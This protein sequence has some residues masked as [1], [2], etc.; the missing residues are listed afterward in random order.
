MQTKRVEHCT[1]ENRLRNDISHSCARACQHCHRT[2]ELRIR[3]GAIRSQQP[4][5]QFFPSHGQYEIILSTYC[6]CTSTPAAV[7]TTVLVSKI[8]G[9]PTAWLHGLEVQDSRTFPVFHVFF[10]YH[11]APLNPQIIDYAS[12][13]IEWYVIILSENCALHDHGTGPGLT[14][15]FAQ[16]AISRRSRRRG[17]QLQIEIVHDDRPIIN[18]ATLKFAGSDT[19]FSPE[20][21]MP[22]WPP[23]RGLGHLVYPC[24]ELAAGQKSCGGGVC[25]ESL[26]PI[27]LLMSGNLACMNFHSRRSLPLHHDSLLQTSRQA[28]YSAHIALPLHICF[29]NRR[30]LACPSYLPYH[31]RTA[32]SSAATR[33]TT[34]SKYRRKRRRRNRFPVAWDKVANI[35]EPTRG[36]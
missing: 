18:L 1:L 23:R 14:A 35:L 11:T 27:S 19:T 7:L 8:Y 24:G 12:R 16:K 26:T 33:G 22:S 34:S 10:S 13:A 17:E 5:I 2:G 6:C 31:L 3:D 36:L 29:V 25:P 21:R 28:F 32:T 9:D 4:S 20:R 15:M 30:T